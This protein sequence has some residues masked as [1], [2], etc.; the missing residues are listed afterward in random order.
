MKTNTIEEISGYAAILAIVAIF[1]WIAGDRPFMG[2]ELQLRRGQFWHALRWF[3]LGLWIASLVASARDD[4]WQE[5]AGI[6][7]ALL[8]LLGTA[9]K[10]MK[11][12]RQNQIKKKPNKSEQATPRK[13]SD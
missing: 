5:G 4:I 1:N 2:R 10:S 13:L 8:L 9:R 7:G 6:A 3:G 12:P 11:A